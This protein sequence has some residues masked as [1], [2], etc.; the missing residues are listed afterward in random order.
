M[1]SANG[2]TSDTPRPKALS[3]APVCDLRVAAGGVNSLVGSS[4]AYVRMWL[5]DSSGLHAGRAADWSP[6]EAHV[7][8]SGP[9]PAGWVGP[10]RTGGHAGGGRDAPGGALSDRR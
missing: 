7:E 4:R 5:A 8:L 6:S 1:R 3:S 2:G 9:R 10:K